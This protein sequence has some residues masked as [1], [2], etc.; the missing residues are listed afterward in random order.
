MQ[1]AAA[2]LVT[3]ARRRYHTHASVLLELC[4]TWLPVRQR[5][6]FKIARLVFQSLS[7]PAP[8]YSIND[9]RIVTGP[10]RSFDSRMC[11]VPRTNSRFVTAASPPPIY[12]FGTIQTYPRTFDKRQGPLSYEHFKRQLK[13]DLFRDHGGL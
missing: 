1:N 7:G 5:F 8:E 6:A 9:C 2:R 11:S 10:R 12:T 13:T 4:T 3:G